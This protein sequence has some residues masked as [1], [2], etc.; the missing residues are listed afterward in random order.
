MVVD[1]VALAGSIAA[2]SARP[3]LSHQSECIGTVPKPALSRANEGQDAH[4]LAH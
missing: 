2:K 3:F 1:W 4:A